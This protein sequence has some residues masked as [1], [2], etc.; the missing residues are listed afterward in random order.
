L[1]CTTCG[2]T[3]PA[4][5]RFCPACGSAMPMAAP[6]PAAVPTAAAPPVYGPAMD[7][8]TW[9]NRALGYIIDALLIGVVM[10]LLYG[11]AG[12]M[13]TGLA[14]LAGKDAA[15]GMCCLLLGLFPIASLAVGIYNRVYLVALRGASIGQ[16]VMKLKVVDAG[17]NLLTQGTALIRLLAQIGMSLVPFLP[18]LDL[19]WPLWDER[20]QTLH[21][22]AV[23]CYVINNPQG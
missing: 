22:K 3:V 6:V 18:V 17:G 8:A 23:S 15:G 2:A 13:L 11:L 14:G 9:A 5:V 20:R 16:G 4:G 12:G 10:A 7:Y 19:L 1:F 21:D